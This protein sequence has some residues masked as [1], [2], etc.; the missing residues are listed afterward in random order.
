MLSE[1]LVEVKELSRDVQYIKHQLAEG[2]PQAATTPTLP[3]QLPLSTEEDFIQAES[4][5][6]DES[7]RKQMV[8][9][10]S[11]WATLI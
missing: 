7:I 8:S 3:I 4:L 10:W 9:Y 6:E 11:D 1:V 5:L 2:M